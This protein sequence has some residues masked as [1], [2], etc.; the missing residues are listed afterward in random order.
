MPFSNK[1]VFFTEENT[2]LKNGTWLLKFNG[3]VLSLLAGGG[4]I[5]I[6]GIGYLTFCLNKLLI[7]Q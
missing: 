6:I 2:V 4:A 7:K 1:G 5:K 3:D